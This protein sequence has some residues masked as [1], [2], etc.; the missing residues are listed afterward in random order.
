ME[1][2][3]GLMVLLNGTSS[4]VQKKSVRPVVTRSLIET[5]EDSSAVHRLESKGKSKIGCLHGGTP[6]ASLLS[7]R[8]T[9][10]NGE[11]L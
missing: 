8:G 10:A 6:L 2:G 5:P 4:A 9:L 3:A 7:I 11:R 1:S